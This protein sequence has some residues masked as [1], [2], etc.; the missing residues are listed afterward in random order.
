MKKFVSSEVAFGTGPTEL[1]G[2]V[3]D[4]MVIR[5]SFTAVDG[6]LDAVY[7]MFSTYM[8]SNPG[9]I[10]M[11]I[12]DSRNVT[13][14]SAVVP[15]PELQD[16]RYHRFEL[17]LPLDVGRTYEVR[18]RTQHCRSGQSATVHHAS[19]RHQGH[20]FIGSKLIPKRE[21]LCKF[22]YATGAEAMDVVPCYDGAFG[23]SVSGVVSVVITHFNRPGSL[24]GCLESVVRQTYSAIEVVVVDDG[25]DISMR[26][27]ARREVA[28]FQSSCWVKFVAHPTNMGANAARNTGFYHTSGS[29]IFFLDC[30]CVLDRDAFASLLNALTVNPE[31]AYSYC[32]YR[33][34]TQERPMKPFKPAILLEGNYISTMSMVRRKSFLG[35]DETLSRLQDWDLWL[36][37][38]RK[39]RHGVWVERTLFETPAMDGLTSDDNVPFVRAY[40]T[41]RTK[42]LDFWKWGP[43]PDLKVSGLMV[44]F[45]AKGVADTAYRSVRK[46]YPKMRLVVVEGSGAEHECRRHFNALEKSDPNLVVLRYE[47]NVGHGRG[48]HIGMTTAQSDYVFVFDSDMEMV[49]GG[50]VESMLKRMNKGT[51]GA[52]KLVYVDD[53]GFNTEPTEEAIPY[54]HPYAMVVNRLRYM[55]Y[56]PFTNHGAPSIRVMTNIKERGFSGKALVDFPVDHYIRHEGKGTRSLHGIGGQEGPAPVKVYL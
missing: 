31:A 46:F 42:H 3:V 33:V 23:E 13:M 39:G 14:G 5:Q 15:S 1:T 34:G 7:I 52:G 25:S 21:L 40:N 49:K 11:S 47:Y 41:V 4:G 20:F 35:F 19:A 9:S 44:S 38:C 28:E 18:L 55:S 8:R 17:A 2:P 36:T 51:W 29:Y 43:R 27:A 10:T 54:V 6:L 16:N 30:D 45:R 37:M 56:M 24:R 50:V 12:V 22:E 48:M 53:V 26:E 32:G